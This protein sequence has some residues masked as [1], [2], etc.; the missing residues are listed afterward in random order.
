M[1]R[2]CIALADH[3]ASFCSLFFS[4]SFLKYSKYFRN[5]IYSFMVKRNFKNCGKNFYIESPIYLHGAQ[6][7]EIG[8]D[9]FCFERLRLETF[10]THN[11]FTFNP[12]IT[13]G[14][15]VSINYDCHIGCI[16]S[17]TIGNNVLIASKV[18]ITDHFHGLPNLESLTLPP[19]K[20]G[21]VS[22]GPVIIADNVWIG[23]GVT[24]MPNVTIGKNAIIGANAVVTKSFP[25]NAVIAGNPAKCIKIIQ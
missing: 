10:E 24:I 7:I 1:K 12:K 5:R 18:F 8:D 15:N 20:R 19:N 14:N 9:F 4:Y 2:I 17:I 21:L 23:E 13:I 11:Q 16:N 22:K 25:E 3:V 6:N